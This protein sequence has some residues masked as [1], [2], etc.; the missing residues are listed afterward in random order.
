MMLR[1]RRGVVVC[2]GAINFVVCNMHGPE[3]AACRYME[4]A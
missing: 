1:L 2:E 3:N 4:R